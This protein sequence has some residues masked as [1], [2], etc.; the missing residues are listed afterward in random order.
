MSENVVFV[1]GLGLS[2]Y[3]FREIVRS[4]GAK[5]VHAVAIDLPGN[6]FSDKSVMEIG[7][8]SNGVLGRFWDV[9][10]EIQANGLFWAFDQ[11]VETGQIPYEEIEA[12]K[13]KR[14]VSKPIELDSEEV[15][16][17]LGQVIETMG[18]SP[19]HL[20][21]HDSALG[22]SANWVLENSK[23]VRSVTLLDPAPRSVPAL[24]LWA[25]E[26]PVI[27]EFVLG[28][29]FVYPW[30]IKKCCSRGIGSS[31]LEAHRVLLKS[32]DARRALVGMGKK[33][34][35][36]FD[37]AEWGGSD[38]L[39]DVPLQVIW[40]KSWS[41][42]WSEEGERVAEALAQASFVAHSGGRWPQEDSADQVAQ[43]IFQ[44]VS[45]LPATVRE[46]VKERVPEHIQRMLDE[47]KI[48]EH[49]HHHGHGG[50]DHHHGSHGLAHEAGFMDAYG[51]GHG[52]GHGHG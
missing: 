28:F 45:A 1:H 25:L 32:R 30:L 15:G 23:S 20:V 13:S 44:F 31:D 46:V 10:S 16:K 52:H 51:L 14:K 12:R 22:M 9:Y 21:L 47:A 11:M 6:G 48:N 17:V 2:S 34:N 4:L 42:E 43:S 37:I 8:R 38:E 33:L 40:S 41:K 3:S 49:H 7:R 19:V 24:H 5:G 36:S 39:K 50:H 27:R 29:S 18:L 35:Y 26:M